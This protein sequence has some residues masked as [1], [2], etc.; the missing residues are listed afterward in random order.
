MLSSSITCK[1]EERTSI[2]RLD[3]LAEKKNLTKVTLKKDKGL[4]AKC[5]LIVLSRDWN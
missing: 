4:H 5:C 2:D 1:N 3:N